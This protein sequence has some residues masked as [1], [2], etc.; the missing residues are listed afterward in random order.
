MFI[1]QHSMYLGLLLRSA[2]IVAKVGIKR[3][4]APTRHCNSYFA[5]HT[6]VVVAMVAS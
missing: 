3:Q 6:Y 5:R 1:A 4:P 2:R